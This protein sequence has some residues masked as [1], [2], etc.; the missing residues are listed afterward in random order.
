MENPM[1]IT[2][3]SAV[4]AAAAMGVLAPTAASVHEA[5][6]KATPKLQQAIP[7]IPGKSLVAFVVDTGDMPLNMPAAAL[8]EKK[9]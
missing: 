6:E 1:N 5:T 3:P 9:Q 2:M 4:V 8:P 7:N